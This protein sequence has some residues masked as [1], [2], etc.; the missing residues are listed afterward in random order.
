MVQPPGKMMDEIDRGG[1]GER[2]LPEHTDNEREASDLPRRIRSI[3]D[4][5]LFQEVIAEIEE[6]RSEIK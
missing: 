2:K 4:R 3:H 1:G 5:P 6:K